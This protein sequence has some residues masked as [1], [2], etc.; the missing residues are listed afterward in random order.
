MSISLQKLSKTVVS[1]KTIKYMKL[2]INVIV[3][4]DENNA[5]GNKGDLLDCFLLA[6]KLFFKKL[7]IGYGVISGR[8]TYESYPEAYRPLPDRHNFILTR[9]EQYV[10]SKT[11]DKTFI[12]RSMLAALNAAAEAGLEKIF[13]GGGSEI[14]KEILD[15]GIVDNIYLTR[16]K[17]TFEAD[18]YFP[19]VDWSQWDETFLFDQKEI[20]QKNT[21]QFET[22]QCS[23]NW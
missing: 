11:N 16:I 14:Y 15:M 2:E 23:R 1:G 13:I 22:F 12:K 5:I 3:A 10:P 7:T 17:G 21:H 9:D 18:K 6:D 8:V 4:I 20:S 19:D